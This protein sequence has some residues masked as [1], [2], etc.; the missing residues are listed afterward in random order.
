MRSARLSCHC[1]SKTPS[2]S[3]QAH[4]HS[5]VAG[6][7]HLAATSSQLDPWTLIVT[8]MLA[9]PTR[10]STRDGAGRRPPTTSGAAS[11][12]D[13]SSRSRSR[14]RMDENNPPGVSSMRCPFRKSIVDPR[15]AVCSSDI[16]VTT[17]VG[18]DGTC[19]WKGSTADG[20]L[21]SAEFRRLRWN[22]SWRAGWRK[23]CARSARQRPGSATRRRSNPRLAK[24][25]RKNN[26]RFSLHGFD[27][28]VPFGEEAV[29][30]D[31]QLPHLRP[32]DLD[33]GLVGLAHQVRAHA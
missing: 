22:G 33:A 20:H 28:V 31:A 27:G 16:D 11:A 30:C 25:R 3:G 7:S 4:V 13:P 9:P 23:R 1:V 17:A 6:N 24:G 5:S 26:F 8:E 21:A 32:G 18:P 29:R 14:D 15:T 19:A 12:Y 10:L 2:L